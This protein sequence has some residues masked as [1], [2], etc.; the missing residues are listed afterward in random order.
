MRL[1]KNKAGM[2]MRVAEGAG[3]V[4]RFVGE[5]EACRKYRCACRRDRCEGGDIDVKEGSDSEG[6]GEVSDWD[7]KCEG[8]GVISFPSGD[9]MQPQ[10]VAGLQSCCK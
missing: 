7:G 1:D 3:M 10:G 4:M 5:K 2:V 6:S 9:G 8:G